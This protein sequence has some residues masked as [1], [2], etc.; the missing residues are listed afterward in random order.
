L[1]D[2]F[3]RLPGPGFNLNARY[4]AIFPKLLIFL[5]SPLLISFLLFV[6]T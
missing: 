4:L 6:E 2:G 3:R 1:T 5:Y